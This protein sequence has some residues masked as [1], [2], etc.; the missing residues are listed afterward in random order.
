MSV[1]LC[2]HT[3]KTSESLTGFREIWHVRV[4]LKFVC[5]FRFSLNTGHLSGLR[6]FLLAQSDALGNP[7]TDLFAVVSDVTFIKA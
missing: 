1:C 7:Q 2:I 4:L 6:A 5:T 3:H